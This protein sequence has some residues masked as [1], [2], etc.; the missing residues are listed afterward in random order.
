MVKNISISLFRK[1]NILAL[2]SLAM[3]NYFIL[4]VASGLVLSGCSSAYK[5]SETPDD[6]YYSYG[7]QAVRVDTKQQQEEEIY[8]SYFDGADDN[9]LRMKVRDR[10]RW[11]EIDDINYW[12]GYNNPN[13]FMNPAQ[14]NM[15]FNSWHGM[16][17]WNN[18][19]FAFNSF[20]MGWGWNNMGWGMNNP[21]MFNNFY[22]S[23]NNPSCWNR[24]VVVVNKFP[25]GS[26][27]V[28]PF[29][30]RPGFNSSAYNNSVFD[31]S[32]NNPGRSS[33]AQGGKPAGYGTGD[34]FRSIFSNGGSSGRNGSSQQGYSR[35]ARFFDNSPSSSG[36]SSFGSG[37][38]GGSSRSSGG[39]GSSSSGGGSRGG[40]GGN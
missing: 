15:G 24:P 9:Y 39:G 32:N 31:R 17:M 30:P 10:D 5:V 13:T 1:R 19:P 26:S 6:V 7:Q 12:Y 8:S 40:R 28:R 11:N 22:N 21:F 3:K 27:N 14:F 18:N 36:G 23:W 16:N 20:N 25:A 35:P 38:G 2:K 34:L 4:L 33:N 37:G 29:Q